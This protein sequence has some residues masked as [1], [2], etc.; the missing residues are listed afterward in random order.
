MMARREEKMKEM[1]AKLERVCRRAGN[2]V[3]GRNLLALVVWGK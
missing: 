2:D 3:E 1:D